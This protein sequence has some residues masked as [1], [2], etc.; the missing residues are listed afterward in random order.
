VEKH[1]IL[2]MV[3]DSYWAKQI[4]DAAWGEF[5]RQITY[6]GEWYGRDVI[7][8]SSTEKKTNRTCHICG[9]VNNEQ[10]LSRVKKWTCPNCH[11]VLKRG[12]NGAVNVLQVC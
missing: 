8:I 1:Q 12:Y 9:A 5:V 6:K 10:D 3:Q 11:T 2:D 4:L 7:A